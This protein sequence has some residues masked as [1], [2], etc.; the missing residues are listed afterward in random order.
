MNEGS[1]STG[2]ISAVN[3]VTLNGTTVLKLDGSGVND[4]VLS[5]AAITYG[6]TLQLVNISGS[7]LAVGNSFQIFSGASYAGTFASVIPAAPGFGLAW[8]TSQLNNGII[9]VVSQPIINSVANSAGHLIFSGTNGPANGTYYVLTTTNLA[10]PANNWVSL[11]TNSFDGSGN[12]SVTNA[13]TPG[14]PQQF[15]RIEQSP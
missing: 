6:G 13:I 3:A 9:S 10:T 5:G 1:N 12:F 4:E 14:R 15:Y 8:D 2:T 11:A 7:P